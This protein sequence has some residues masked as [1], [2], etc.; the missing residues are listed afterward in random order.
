[1]L[2]SVAALI[3]IEAETSLA[4]TSWLAFTQNAILERQRVCCTNR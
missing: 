2:N 3:P 1:M 4:V